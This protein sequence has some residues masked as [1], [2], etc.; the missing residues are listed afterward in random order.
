[1]HNFQG[2]NN[3]KKKKE[4]EQKREREIYIITYM[5]KVIPETLRNTKL[6]SNV[7]IKKGDNKLMA[8]NQ[9]D[10]TYVRR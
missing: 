2:N 6:D 7:F 4:K 10:F 8:I 3:N 9:P 1:M 5:T